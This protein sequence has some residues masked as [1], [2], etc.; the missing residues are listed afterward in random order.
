MVDAILDHSK[1]H[2]CKLQQLSLRDISISPD[3]GVK[4]AELIA[5][6]PHLRVLDLSENDLGESTADALFKSLQ[7]RS[8]SLE[9]FG[10][11]Y[12]R[13]SPSVGFPMSDELYEFAK[14]GALTTGRHGQEEYLCAHA[15]AQFLLSSGGRRLVKLQIMCHDITESG[16]LELAGA[17]AKA[18]ALRGIYISKSKLKPRDAA[19][20]LDALATASTM[21]MDTIHF[22]C[23]DIGYD[24]ASAVGRLILH[25]GCRNVYLP[26]N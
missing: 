25:R 19:V 12:C 6:S 9:E 26:C 14:R 20:I 10:V 5:H 23:C 16:A 11:N 17:L 3:G 1:S 7:L 8:R 24:G 18:Y 21:P 13:L 4:L 15:L 22:D 2:R